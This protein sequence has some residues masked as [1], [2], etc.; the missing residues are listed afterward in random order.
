MVKDNTAH[1]KSIERAFLLVDALAEE[2]REHSL[3]E[4]A[5]TLGWPKSTVHGVISTLVLYRYVEQ[6]EQTGRYRL[7]IRFFE[8]RVNTLWTIPQG[9]SRSQQA[10]VRNPCLFLFLSFTLCK[11]KL[12]RTNDS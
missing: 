9:L 11:I 8:L 5:T 3:T 7:G 6:S 10:H 2:P 12:L 4:L 1:I